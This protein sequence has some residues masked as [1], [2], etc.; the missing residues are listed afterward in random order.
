ME[1]DPA[2]RV[3]PVA[4]SAPGA[5]DLLDQPVVALGAGIGDASLD[6]R[7]SQS[8]SLGIGQRGFAHDSR[9]SEVCE[10]RAAVLRD[11]DVA[12]FNV[13]MHDASG[14]RVPEGPCR[15]F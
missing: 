6:E 12:W 8:P 13:A 1:S 2:C 4:E 14:V 7:L 10:L 11:K 15:A 3:V 5:L 9:Y